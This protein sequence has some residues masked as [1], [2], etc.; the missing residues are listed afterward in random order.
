MRRPSGRG[1]GTRAVSSSRYPS[2]LDGLDF[3]QGRGKVQELDRP[4]AHVTAE[5][6]GAAAVDSRPTLGRVCQ[7]ERI[8]ACPPIIIFAII[9]ERATLYTFGWVPGS[10]QPGRP[11]EQQAAAGALD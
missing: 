4:A 9:K 1:T 11:Q 6:A 3:L 7:A 10:S 2:S 8:V 5:A